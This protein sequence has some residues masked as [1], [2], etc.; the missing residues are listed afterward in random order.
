[1]TTP[2]WLGPVR[3]TAFVVS[4]IE[5]VAREWVD[6]HGVGPWFLYDVDIADTEYRGSVVPLRARMGLAQSG[7]QQIE[8]IQPDPD[9]PSLYTEFTGRGGTGVHHVCYW[10]DLDRALEHFAASGAE[11]VQRGTTATG[12]SFLYMSG[13]C[14]VPYIEFVN[15]NPAMAGFF[16][17]IAACALDWDGSDPIRG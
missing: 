10:A 9:Q 7:G 8:L 1:M 3:Q 16:A 5:A 6:V 15:P 13:S 11:V 2:T 17:H 12:V 4:D 14:G